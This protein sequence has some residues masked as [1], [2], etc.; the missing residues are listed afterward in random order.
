M[1]SW[2]FSVAKQILKMKTHAVKLDCGHSIRVEAQPVQLVVPK[3]LEV[4]S[5]ICSRRILVS[6][7]PQMEAESLEDKLGYH[8]SR[9]ANGGGEVETCCLDRDTGTAV[10]LF[11]E[12]GSEDT[13]AERLWPPGS[14]GPPGNSVC[15]AVADALVLKEFHNIAVHNA[16]HTVRVAPFVSGQMS[17]LEVSPPPASRLLL[18]V[19]G[20]AVVLAPSPGRRRAPGRCC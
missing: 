2:C 18:T 17:R 12:E 4:E 15:P 8:F 6:D 7:L 3:Q 14:P 5:V 10:L 16:T 11:S 13:V 20:D 19:R 1:F 9:K